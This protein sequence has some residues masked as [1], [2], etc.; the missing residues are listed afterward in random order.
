MARPADL[1][2]VRL[3][4]GRVVRAKSTKALRY[5]I[6]SG[7]I[8]VAARVRRDPADDW[9][10]LEWS[11]EFADLLSVEASPGENSTGKAETAPSFERAAAHYQAK[12]KNDA[13]RS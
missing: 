3:P 11:Q 4:S 10:A 6:R 5:H 8:P 7:R 1:W 2:Y 13:F 12:A 9:V